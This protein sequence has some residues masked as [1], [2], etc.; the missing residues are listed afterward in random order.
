MSQKVT[1]EINKKTLL[2]I[3]LITVGITSFIVFNK[4]DVSANPIEETYNSLKTPTAKKLF[5]DQSEKLTKEVPKR[6]IELDE[7]TIGCFGQSKIMQMS[8]SDENLGGQCCG[9]LKDIESYDIQV[10]VLSKFIKDHDNVELIPKDPYDI[11]VEHAQQLTSFDQTIQLNQEQQNTYDEA[12]QNSHHGGPCC[13]KCWKW[14]VM[15]GLA[16]KLIVDY[17]WNS[18][19]ITEL[20]DLSSSCGHAEDTNMYEHYQRKERKHGH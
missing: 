17:D 16:K 1:I 20:W 3:L 2:I 6:L 13:C 8:A 10:E 4:N 18:E 11:I 15:S 12:M 19:D 14:Y 7:K 9:A 5:Y